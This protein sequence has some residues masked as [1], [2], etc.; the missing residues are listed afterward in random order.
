MPYNQDVDFARKLDSSLMED[1]P[2]SPKT[3]SSNESVNPYQSTGNPLAS[4]E[5]AAVD[6]S[7]VAPDLVSLARWQTVLA[8]LLL[9][10]AVLAGAFI[11]L[12]MIAIVASG[13]YTATGLLMPIVFLVVLLFIYALPGWLL[14]R[15]ASAARNYFREG[16]TANLGA[17]V[18]RQAVFWRVLVVMLFAMAMFYVS[19]MVLTWSRFAAF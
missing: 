2:G 11:M 16:T 15:A 14:W 12:R 13:A 8:A 19:I 1:T 4:S 3:D 18:K 10:V 17:F 6:H 7:T 5:T 9:F